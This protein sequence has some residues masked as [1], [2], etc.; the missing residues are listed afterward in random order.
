MTPTQKILTVAS[1]AHSAA[2]AAIPTFYVVSKV[3]AYMEKNDYP[4]SLTMIAK[5]MTGVSTFVSAF[6]ILDASGSYTDELF[7]RIIKSWNR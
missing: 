7:S 2:V 1:V 6:A 4:N 3:T 5:T